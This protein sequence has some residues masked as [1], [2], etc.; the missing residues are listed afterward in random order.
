MFVYRLAFNDGS[1]EIEESPLGLLDS[2]QCISD[3]SLA[4]L[5]DGLD[6]ESNVGYLT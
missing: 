4:E 3:V 6:I 1:R 2:P 5:L